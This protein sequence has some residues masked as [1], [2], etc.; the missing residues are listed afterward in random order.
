M[1][2]TKIILGFLLIATVE[3]L[4]GI[5][6]IRYLHKRLGAKKAKR[7]SFVSG[8][9]SVVLINIFLYPAIAPQS[10]LQALFVGM[11]WTFLMVCY[12]LYVGRVLFK[13]SWDKVFD[14]FNLFKGNLLSLGMILILILPPL[15]FLLLER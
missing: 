4:N 13:L 2:L 5:F 9:L 7:V 8:S 11:F 6:R 10:F 12:D 15:L 1:M 14:D 3:T